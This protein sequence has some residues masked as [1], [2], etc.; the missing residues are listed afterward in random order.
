MEMD[1]TLGEVSSHPE[2]DLDASDLLHEEVRGYE[3]S[4]S[5]GRS[6]QDFGADEE[7]DLVE[8]TADG[9][10]PEVIPAP[11]GGSSGSSTGQ[12]IDLVTEGDHKNGLE[13]SGSSRP[14]RLSAQR[15]NATRRSPNLD[16]TRPR[17]NVV[18]PSSSSAAPRAGSQR[19]G[20]RFAGRELSDEPV[21]S[22]LPASKKNS[23][24]LLCAE[25]KVVQSSNDEKELT[26]AINVIRTSVAK[27]KL[28]LPSPPTMVV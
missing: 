4:D 10:F 22:T 9:S 11:S 6:W 15:F 24:Q 27:R 2:A 5:R 3:S 19:S 17:R 13:S 25:C 23:Y 8:F 26:R 20:R 1:V 12:A 16:P 21:P 28:S 18:S 14:R 7:H